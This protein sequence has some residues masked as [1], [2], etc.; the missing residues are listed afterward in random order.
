MSSQ[1]L[2]VF[3]L[4]SLYVVTKVATKE[5]YPSNWSA[6]KKKKMTASKKKIKLYKKPYDEKAMWAKTLA[7]LPDVPAAAPVAPLVM[8]A[9]PVMTA[10]ATVDT[11]DYSY[12]DPSGVFQDRSYYEGRV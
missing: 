4:L 12:V 3:A 6:A 2:L 9:S 10:P 11:A 8:T 1:V 7:L 5:G